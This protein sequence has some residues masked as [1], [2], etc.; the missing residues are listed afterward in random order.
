MTA[1]DT[2]NGWTNRETWALNLVLSNDQGLA[3]MT[4]ERV[5][6]VLAGTK[7]GLSTSTARDAGEAVK[8]LFEEL[9]DPNYGVLGLVAIVRLLREVGGVW[10]ID[11][12]EI[13]AAWL[14]NLS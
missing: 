11:W 2:Y 5:A 7:A 6:E 9:T 4:R 10:R 3:E 1:S 12:R 8:Q 13:G 14:E